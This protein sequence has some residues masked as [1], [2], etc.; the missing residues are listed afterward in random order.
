MPVTD[1]THATDEYQSLTVSRLQTLLGDG[2]TQEAALP[3][4]VAA[5]CGTSH[6]QL[7]ELVPALMTSAQGLPVVVVIYS[8]SSYENHPRRTASVTVLLLAET[9]DEA[10]GRAI[11]APL[12]DRCLLLL[13][14]H[15]DD[16]AKWRA[17]DDEALDI[18]PNLSCFKLSFEILDA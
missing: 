5:F 13:D 8:G 14:E 15:I 1:Y 18:G 11:L 3:W 9:P 4:A 2:E 10:A 7:W 6:D 16:Q 12:V 17:K